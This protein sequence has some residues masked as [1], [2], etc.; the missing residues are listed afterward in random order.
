M[1]EGALIP[2]EL[3]ITSLAH[4]SSIH[5]H[6]MPHKGRNPRRGIME[7]MKTPPDIRFDDTINKRSTNEA[8][9]PN[10][11]RPSSNGA[12]QQPDQQLQRKARGKRAEAPGITN[13]TTKASQQQEPLR[14]N[15]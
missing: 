13:G 2:L 7:G 8:E 12:S 1:A 11:G 5:R 3:M 10:G 9:A 14:V 4:P 6:P 15:L